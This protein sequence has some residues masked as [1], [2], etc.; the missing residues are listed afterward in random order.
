MQEAF[1][2]AEADFFDSNKKDKRSKR[3]KLDIKRDL[4]DEEDQFFGSMTV[5]GKLPKYAEVLKFKMLSLGTK[6]LGAILEVT[7]RELIIGLPNGLRGH[8]SHRQSS[9]VLS[10]EGKKPK[11]VLTEVFSIGQLVRCVVIKLQDPSLAS[12]SKAA[13]GKRIDVSLHV[14]NVNAGI[15]MDALKIDFA[16]PACVT[17]VED[18]GYILSFGVQGTGGFLPKSSA[19]KDLKTGSIV[20]VVI[21]SEGPSGKKKTYIVSA[22]RD[23]VANAAAGEWDG[24]T[25]GS[26]LPGSL[27]AARVRS[28]LSDGLLVSF[29]T[30]FSGTIDPFHISTAPGKDWQHAFSDN[31]RVKARLLY[32]D[33]ISKKVGLTLLKPLINW[34]L[35]RQSFP[36]LG[37]IFENAVV[38]RIDPNVGLLV[39]LSNAS[40]GEGP[41]LVDGYAHISNV[42]DDKVDT[43]EGRFRVGQKLRARVIGFRPLDCL[44]ALSLKPQVLD[45]SILSVADIRPGMKITAEVLSIE[46]DDSGLIV[47]ISSTLK[48]LVPFD[49]ISDVPSRKALKKFKVGVKV[50]GRVLQVDSVS[51]KVRVTLKPMLVDSKLPVITSFEE[52][53]PGSRSHGTVTGVKDFGVFVGFYN[54]I[55]GL[56]PA[57]ECGLPEGQHPVDAF[58]VGQPVKCKIFGVD[59]QHKGLKLSFLLS[60]TARS[61]PE[62][63]FTGVDVGSTV[64]GIV[65]AIVTKD[66]D[67]SGTEK[68]PL[69]FELDLMKGGERI[70]VVGKMEAGHLSD[71]PVAA[72]ALGDALSKG[73]RLNSLRVLQHL[74]TAKQVK[75]TNKMSLKTCAELPSTL[76]ELRE[77]HVLP[78]YVASVTPDAVF[79]RFAGDLTGRAGLAQLSDSFISDP[80]SHFAFNQSIYAR[81]VNV[82]PEKNRCSLTL[83][84]TATEQPSSGCNT[85]IDM[86]AAFFQDMETAA[87]LG[88]DATVGGIEWASA[89]PIGATVSGQ[90][91]EIKEYGIICDVDAHPDVVG[92]VAFH[93]APSPAPA[94]GSPFKAIVMDVNKKD[95]IID[96][97]LLLQESQTAKKKT[98]NSRSGRKPKDGDVQLGQVLN[99][100]KVELVSA[101]EGYC[102]V[103]M[104]NGSFGFLAAEDMSALHSILTGSLRLPS[105]GD[106][107]DARVALI[108]PIDDRVLLLP[109]VAPH[110]NE[111]KENTER[112]P[113]PEI[114]SIV[115]A[116]ITAVHA[117]HIDVLLEGNRHG[118]V[119]ITNAVEW[120]SSAVSPLSAF[121]VGTSVSALVLGRAEG[122]HRGLWELSTKQS[123]FGSTPSRVGAV[124]EGGGG[125]GGGGEKHPP[126]IWQDVKPGTVLN[127]WVTESSSGSRDDHQQIWV[128]FAPSIKGRADTVAMVDSVDKCAGVA[129]SYPIGT[130]VTAVVLRAEPGKHVLDIMLGDTANTTNNSSQALTPQVA[131][132][133]V[134]I[135]GRVVAVSGA[136]VKIRLAN[137]DL[138]MVAL[139]D[140]HDGFVENALSGLEAGQ[141]ARVR[142]LSKS[143]ADG[144]WSLMLK[145]SQGGCIS[146]FA[147]QDGREESAAEPLKLEVNRRVTG[148]VRSVSRAGVFIELNRETVGRVRLRNLANDYVDN[149][150][151]AFPEGKMVT[152][153]IISKSGDKI[154]VSLRSGRQAPDLTSLRVGQVVQGR[155]KRIEP[156]GVFVE[157]QG[158]GITGLAHKSELADTFVKD[159]GSLFSVGQ[160]VTARV[161]DIDLKESR[162]SMGLKP[163]YLELGDE[164]VDENGENEELEVIEQADE[165][166]GSFDLDAELEAMNHDAD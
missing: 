1:A 25:I 24:L 109:Y 151:E 97:S 45:Q 132:P 53:V 142:V 106:S 57:A 55:S 90:V 82:D 85:T 13:K 11:V 63:P 98:K 162:I 32:I 92:L 159:P 133:G 107:V 15:T 34:S 7:P 104:P 136:G 154:E 16:L 4:E 18:H 52:A 46:P 108:C 66:T 122:K 102:V 58:K 134:L 112:S 114:G 36:D 27:V 69:S 118:R 75:L 126:L 138:G 80:S 117:A 56:V 149:P 123:L 65:R 91:H 158:G 30:F 161:L 6:L 39:E 147:Q 165:E 61:S 150:G 81:V 156:F 2:E 111:P 89:F 29:L 124:C 148:Y 33:P 131:A 26:L 50:P 87:L 143:E 59:Q 127:G 153:K 128:S 137:G 20:D 48:A 101:E 164:D 79:V 37:R 139:S 130:P 8:V 103:S 5:Q 43:L 19:E 60:A 47:A 94:P 10:H 31:Q 42:S 17:S 93:Q 78:G 99:G 38:K 152:G 76:K 105:P 119:H 135:L 77:G 129:S 163:S 95:G 88:D 71:H 144:M 12:T 157:M 160:M 22:H 86:L 49:H 70:G 35:P 73:S 83:K 68:V 9:D 67:D 110:P 125:G 96:L 3:P 40:S 21:Q 41:A 120:S 54:G 146:L 74:H 23:V 44:A 145:P 141:A 116:T 115:E 28:V 140:I 84:R 72:K 51:K 64:D 166:E 121:K 100:C 113:P 62:S 155:V 14:A